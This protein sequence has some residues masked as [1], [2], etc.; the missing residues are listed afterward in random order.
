VETN[1]IGF[2]DSL[3]QRVEASISKDV[4]NKFARFLKQR[5][6]TKWIIS[7]DFCIGDKARAKDAFAFVVFPAGDELN[8]TMERLNRVPKKDLKETRLRPSSEL[9]RLLRKGKI[10]SFCFLSE[11]ENK[12]FTD[13][14]A[15]R[16]C[17]DNS[18]ALMESWENRERC[19]D[20]IK[21]VRAMRTEA[22]KSS[23]S[24]KLL[25]HII[26]CCA[27]A[28][29]IAALITKHGK[30]ELIG[31]VPD[32]DRIT[33]AYS[34]IA[35]I[36]FSVNVAALSERMKFQQPKLGI[37]TQK[38]DNLWCDPYIRVADFVAGAAAAF[39]PP[40]LG[41]VSPKI[42]SMM[43]TFADNPYLAIFL[44]KFDVD[45]Q[46]CQTSVSRLA[47]SRRPFNRR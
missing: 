38:N 33:E 25:T 17:L 19:Q 41:L 11:R 1:S 14:V 29:F 16:T 39:N 32:R 37:F 26:L 20:I 22:N 2:V 12:L 28:A 9:M 43:Q 42:A 3:W 6:V 31:W 44:L 23:L 46:I 47:I 27:L 24:L 35:P 40:D 45:G 15:A 36:L 8:A 34:N 7:T 13:A 5:G 30:A 18:I 10:F 21:K 4:E